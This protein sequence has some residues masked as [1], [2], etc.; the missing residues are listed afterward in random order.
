MRPALLEAF[1][2]G[3]RTLVS[4]IAGFYV[5]DDLILSKS[6]LEMRLKQLQVSPEISPWLVRAIV[7]R[8]SRTMCGHVGFHSKPGPEDL[9]GIAPDGVE[10]GY[11]VAERFRRK[12]YAKEA[13]SAMIKW[14]LENHQQQRFILSIA[15]N[16]EASLAMARS[17]GFK[18]IGSHI[19]AED[20]LELYFERQLKHW[21][22]E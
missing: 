3:D 20:G 19:D 21:P 1:L 8:Q 15:P 7:I 17:M 9:R 14:A 16:N 11:S 10:L 2:A 22:E 18:E 12:G 13:V 5:P 4:Q 6:L